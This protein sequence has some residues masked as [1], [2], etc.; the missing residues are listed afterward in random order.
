MILCGVSPSFA[1][2]MPG[3][4]S[5]RLNVSNAAKLWSMDAMI[6]TVRDITPPV[7]DAGRDQKV[8]V[9]TAINLSGASS[10]DNVG[11]VGWHWN[12]SY[13]GKEWSIAGEN[14]TVRF[15][16]AGVYNIVLTV[17]DGAGNR[18]EDRIN[19]TVVKPPAIVD[20]TYISGPPFLALLIVLAV[21]AVGGIYVQLVRRK[22]SVR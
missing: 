5:V 13:D 3:I 16:R 19:I 1:F 12:F 10:K 17:L 15:D 7:A 21:L 9:G 2:D 14:I 22:R 20:K 6:L 11:I 8:A 4:Y 18:G